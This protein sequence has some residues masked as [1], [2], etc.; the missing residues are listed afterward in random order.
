[1]E[2]AVAVQVG[3]TVKAVEA[4]EAV[5]A[6]KITHTQLAMLQLATP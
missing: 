5:K 3:T 1:M 4:V 6:V 2:T